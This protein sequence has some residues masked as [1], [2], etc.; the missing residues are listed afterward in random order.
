MIITI[1][2]LLFIVW[3][4]TDVLPSNS[5]NHNHIDDHNN[6][7]NHNT[8][9]HSPSYSKHSDNDDDEYDSD[10]EELAEYESQYWIDHYGMQKQYVDD[11]HPLA[12]SYDPEMGLTWDQYVDNQMN[13]D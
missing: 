11:E 6:R 9:S 10:E 4:F 8:S 7:T 1:L 3:L 5:A 2:F 12:D 13:D